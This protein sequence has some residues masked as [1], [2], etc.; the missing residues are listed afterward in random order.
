METGKLK[1]ALS[2]GALAL[3][4]ALAGCGGS[5]GSGGATGPEGRVNDDPKPVDCGGGIT[6]TP[7]QTCKQAVD[8]ANEADDMAKMKVADASETFTLLSGYS[9]PGTLGDSATGPTDA[10]KAE[11]KG[12]EII[13]GTG[14]QL[15]ADDGDIATNAP[16]EGRNRGYFQL[17]AVTSARDVTAP[18]KFTNTPAEEEHAV[19]DFSGTYRGIDGTFRCAGNDCTS[20]NRGD[21]GF[22]LGGANWYFRPNDPEAKLQGAIAAEWGWWI[23]KPGED[24]EAFNLVYRYGASGAGT[25]TTASQANALRG[26]ATY[27]GK[28]LGQYAVVDGANSASGAFE[29]TAS[30]TATFGTATAL[31]GSIHTFNVGNGWEVLLKENKL[32]GDDGAATF[33]GE[34]EWKTN[35]EDGV[36]KGSWNASMYG[37]TS[38]GDALPTHVIGGFTAVDAGARMVGAFGG[39]PPKQ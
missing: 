29:A 38:S 1:L 25:P 4:M 21:E 27:T 30:L 35:D 8:A 22:I 9:L 11:Y 15:S 39:E 37:D 26:S 20:Q 2:A 34:T 28:A 33:T 17:A 23:S 18:G 31:S 6:A 3:S 13:Y 7:P 10:V 5:S 32:A 14:A 36:G 19:G 16:T 12:V 24:D